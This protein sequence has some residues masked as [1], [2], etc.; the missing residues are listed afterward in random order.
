MGAW[1]PQVA[2]WNFITSTLPRTPPQPDRQT[3]CSSEDLGKLTGTP[4]LTLLLVRLARICID[5]VLTGLAE[6]ERDALMSQDGSGLKR[7]SDLWEPTLKA[8]LS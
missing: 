6:E 4:S 3:S 2:V 1:S 5:P 7:L 8:L